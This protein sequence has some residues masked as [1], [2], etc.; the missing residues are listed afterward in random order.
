MGH[1]YTK[2]SLVKS[3]VTSVPGVKGF[4][5]IIKCNLDRQTIDVFWENGKIVTCSIL[6]IEKI[7]G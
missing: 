7:S 4:G 5:I 1:E 2:G 6:I 3:K